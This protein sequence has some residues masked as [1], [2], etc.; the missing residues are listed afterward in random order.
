LP[1]K[2]GKEVIEICEKLGVKGTEKAPKKTAKKYRSRLKEER[3]TMGRSSRNRKG[4]KGDIL[5]YRGF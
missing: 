5:F 4:E 1:Q 2:E 3:R